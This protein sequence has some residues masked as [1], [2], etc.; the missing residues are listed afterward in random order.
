M[1][2]TPFKDLKKHRVCDISEDNKV[3][4]IVRGDCITYITANPDGT[5]NVVS[6]HLAA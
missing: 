5:L 2:Y 3:I 6:E 1:D 4:S